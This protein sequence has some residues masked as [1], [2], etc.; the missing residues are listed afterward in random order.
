M[1]WNRLLPEDIRGIFFCEKNCWIEVSSMNK[2]IKPLPHSFF[3]ISCWQ[4]HTKA[5][6]SLDV[7]EPSFG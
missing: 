5:I 7:N 6:E 3:K 2:N 1:E 4:E